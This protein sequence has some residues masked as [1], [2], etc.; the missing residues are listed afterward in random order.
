MPPLIFSPYAPARAQRHYI[1]QAIAARH[2]AIIYAIELSF[3][4]RLLMRRCHF[5]LSPLS[6]LLPMSRH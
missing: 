5:Q 6:L 3:I 1:S 2:I 4:T